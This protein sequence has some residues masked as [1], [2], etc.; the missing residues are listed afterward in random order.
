MDSLFCPD[1]HNLLDLPGEEDFVSC[2]ACGAR[3]SSSGKKVFG[4]GEYSLSVC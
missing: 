4:R 1:C 3:Q 2:A